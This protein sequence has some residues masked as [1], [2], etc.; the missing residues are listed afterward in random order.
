MSKYMKYKVVC[1]VQAST[2]GENM[3]VMDISEL[4]TLCAF[5]HEHCMMCIDGNC[6]QCRLGKTLDQCMTYDRKKNESWA[7][8]EGWTNF[9]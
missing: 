3:T 1:G 2:A 4:D 6:N 5:A 8:W 7:T 9:K